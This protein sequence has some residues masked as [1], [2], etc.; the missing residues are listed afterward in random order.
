VIAYLLPGGIGL[1]GLG[2]L[3]PVFNEW[4][5]SSALTS[6]TIGGFLTATLLALAAGLVASTVRWLTID[7]LH[8][9]TGVKPPQWDFAHLAEREDAYELLVEIHYRY[10]QFYS[11]SI[12]ALTFALVA[13]LVRGSSGVEKL[14][15]AAVLLLFIT[16]FFAGSRDTLR[17]YY[18]RTGDLLRRRQK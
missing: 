16:I 6:V 17:K 11:N 1:W 5:G 10:Y 2:Q 3:S 7:P 13:L 18:G 9:R 8:H 14:S 12:V 4:L 15:F